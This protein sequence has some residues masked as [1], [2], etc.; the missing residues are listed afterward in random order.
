MLALIL[1]CR[2]LLLSIFAVLE[3]NAHS[4][5]IE[6]GCEEIL[7]PSATFYQ[8]V[9]RI[10]KDSEL[11]LWLKRNYCIRFGLW[12]NGPAPEIEPE[13][14]WLILKGEPLPGMPATGGYDGSFDPS[15]LAAVV[16]ARAA[17]LVPIGS[18][19]PRNRFEWEASL[20]KQ[21]IRN[22][23]VLY[24]VDRRTPE[25]IRISGGFL[26]RPD[27]KQHTLWEHV[28]ITSESG[29]FVS[30]T[31]KALNPQVV[32]MVS[33][34]PRYTR[35]RGATGSVVLYEYKLRNVEGMRTPPEHGQPAE[36]EVVTTHIPIAHIL[37][38]RKIVVD[39]ER[40]GGTVSEVSDWTSIRSAIAAPE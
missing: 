5:P 21:E 2:I 11:E 29:S 22:F 7:L 23:E 8:N 20:L 10:L 30:T 38:W 26:P 32:F 17:G 34:A 31:L 25:E 35:L 37:Q 27:S 36:R 6:R 12:K 28:A 18:I 33:Q 1:S 24:R 39:R 9:R 3:P 19:Y 40:N 16:L 14:L 4:E 13:W 15:R